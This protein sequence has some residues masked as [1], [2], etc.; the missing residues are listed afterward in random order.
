MNADI[1][2]ESLFDVPKVRRLNLDLLGREGFVV[3]DSLPYVWLDGPPT[4]RPVD[5]IASRVHALGLLFLWVS[6]PAEAFGTDALVNTF[7]ERKVRE[8]LTSDETLIMNLPRERA[9]EE[10]IDRIG[11]RLE[12]MWSLAWVI[13]FEPPPPLCGQMEL[14]LIKS[15]LFDFLN[16][17]ARSASQIVEQC[18]RRSDEVVYELADRFYCAHNAVRSAQTGRD[19]V[20]R[21]FD[22]FA[23]GG[24]IHERRHG[25]WWVLFP[26]VAWEDV[27]LST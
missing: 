14:E 24:A 5:E 13:G 20:P 16:L 12:N 9:R 11:W 6:T 22:P 15:M 18:R 26:G 21:T 3:A 10:H 8:H 7:T 25:L 27:D 1:K 23:E 2:N 17:P 4:L 19:T